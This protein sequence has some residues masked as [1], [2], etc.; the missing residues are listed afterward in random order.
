MKRY[1]FSM[2]LCIMLFSACAWPLPACAQSGSST[3]QV[4]ATAG[5][6]PPPDSGGGKPEKPDPEEGGPENPD[7][8]D[9]PEGQEPSKTPDTPGD[10]DG[11]QPGAGGGEAI[12]SEPTAVPE[13]GDAAPG[14]DKPS[15]EAGKGGSPDPEDG[16]NTPETG[17]E[18]PPAESMGPAGEGGTAPGD[19][20]NQPQKPETEPSQT[21]EPAQTEDPMGPEGH[22]GGL[23]RLLAALLLLC[24]L[25][26]LAAAGV[27]R[28]LW[29]GLLF[30]FFR[31][32]RRKFHGILTEEKNFFI[33]IRNA[34][35]GSRLA[36][37][38]IDSIGGLAE[39]QAE[40]RKET[41]VTEIPRQCRMRITY[42]GRD[43]RKHC[44]ETE[45]GEQRMFRILEEL[46][47]AGD[48]EVRI[49]C[50]G[51]GINIPLYFCL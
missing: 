37:E 25:A 47:G 6:T 1:L 11:T 36:Q 46:D 51:T 19:G 2:L 7:P 27:F 17:Q 32:S 13:P 31:K 33:H 23:W 39:Y 50:K 44:R 9:G 8:G 22:S 35:D 16:R 18:T 42:A 10:G 45:A 40:I 41:A 4:T 5:E 12:P 20:E 14:A 3:C 34:G 15:P 48:V 21:A 26:V 24:I 28:R 30:A 49:T 29:I 43:G 38:V